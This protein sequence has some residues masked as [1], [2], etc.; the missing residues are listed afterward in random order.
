MFYD[1]F[2]NNLFIQDYATIIK[3]AFDYAIDS[4]ADII[5]C[6]WDLKDNGTNTNSTVIESA[7]IDALENGRSGK[8]SIVVFASGKQF[9]FINTDV[10]YPANFDD[11]IIVVGASTE[12]RTRYSNSRYGNKLDVVAP[13]YFIMTTAISPNIPNFITNIAGGASIAAAHV[14]GVAALMLENNPDLTRDQ[15][16]WILKRTATKFP[17]Y[18]FSSNSSH[19]A[20]TWNTELGYGE[21]H[22]LRAIQS[23][24]SLATHEKLCIKDFSSD[25]GTIPSNTTL[26]VTASPS[27]KVYDA[28]NTQTTMLYSGNTYSVKVTVHNFTSS[29]ISVNP[30]N[31]H[32]YC[33]PSAP[34]MTWNGSFS[35]NNVLHS[36]LVPGKSVTISSGSSHTFTLSLAIPSNYMQN[37]SLPK[38]LTILA[39]VGPSANIHDFGNSN[40]PLEGFVRWNSRVAMNCSCILDE[41]ILPPVNAFGI[42]SISPNPTSGDVVVGYTIADNDSD[43][44]LLLTN[45]YGTPLLR[46]AATGGSCRLATASLPAGQY[47][48]QLIVD[49]T[50]KDTK[51]LIVQ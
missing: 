27:I 42:T 23:V 3:R 29:S 34:N 15:V 32:V 51:P 37:T 33:L 9:D 17:S 41:N 13:G 38:D 22:A 5:L 30:S 1:D 14:A 24:D 20:S 18:T 7:I 2:P 50:V 11:R 26:S 12:S 6:A 46:T 39:Y 35:G 44:Q 25:N 45:T 31:V 43:V 8:G 4:S 47:L 40:A 49:N 10:V 36:T 48:V 28:S 16:E 19:P 21:I